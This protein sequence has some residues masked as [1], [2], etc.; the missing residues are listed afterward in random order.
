[1]LFNPDWTAPAVTD[2][3]FEFSS[4]RAWLETMPPDATYNYADAEHCAIGRYLEAVC[5]TYSDLYL[6]APEYRGYLG[7]R[8]KWHRAAAPP[9]AGYFGTFGAAAKRA[10]LLERGGWR[11]QL[12][13]LMGRV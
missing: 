7:L 1:M 10:R 5:A 12:A 6:R 4:F 2:T 13:E 9:G 8:C 11:L 3:R